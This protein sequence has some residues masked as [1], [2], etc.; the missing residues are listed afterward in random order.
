MKSK[1]LLI[2]LLA[3][4]LRISVS[5][6]GYHGDLNNNISWGTIAYEKGLNGFYEGYQDLDGRENS[7]PRNDSGEVKWPYSAPNQPPLTILTLAGARLTWQTFRNFIW[8]M[9]WQLLIFPSKIVWFWDDHGMTLLVKLP[10]IVA[11]SAIGYFIYKYFREKNKYKTGLILM[12]VWLFN[13]ITWYNSAIWGQTDAIVN[14]LGFSAILKLTRKKL[15]Q[16]AIL[17][18]LSILFKGSLAIFVPVLLMY[19]IIERF[20]TYEWFK[21]SF[22]CLIT[23][24]LVSVWFHPRLDLPFWLFNLYSERIL[25]GEIGF[26]T[27]NA[28]NFWWLINPGK[29]YDS[30]IFLGLTAR[31]WGIV[32]TLMFNSV[33]IYWLYKKPKA[34]RLF[35]ALMIVSLAS[36]LFM[37]RIH[38]RYM[39][40][41]FP[42]STL[43]LGIDPFF[44]VIYTLFSITHLFNMYN[45]FWVPG[46][47]VLEN[48][49]VIPIVPVTFSLL[50]LIL[51]ILTLRHLKRST[52]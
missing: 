3:F 11:D 31:M 19:A 23:I 34:E 26:L 25:P 20:S 15:P 44:W 9:N 2:L 12:I 29:I 14:L 43:F 45:L 8:Y 18:T 32:L 33:A 39:Y 35:A 38:E 21:S 49:L 30:S 47:K 27:A 22:Y 17:F 51:F 46:I 37:T 7:M 40:P 28:F 6:V 41:F 16:F 13:P 52:I 24:L 50:N 1:I 10:S 36:F 48:L 4:L 5:L 42:V